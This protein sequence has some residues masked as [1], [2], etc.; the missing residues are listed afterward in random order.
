MMQRFL[1]SWIIGVACLGCRP[2]EMKSMEELATYVND[3]ENGLAIQTKAGDFTFKTTVLPTDRLVAMEI[4]EGEVKPDTVDKW[5]KHFDDFLYFQLSISRNGKEALHQLEDHAM[6]AELVNVLS[7]QM[8]QHVN[9]TTASDTIPVHDYILNRTYGLSES[10]DLLFSFKREK[11][12]NNEWIQFNVNEF[13]LGVGNQRFRF[14]KRD[15][16]AVPTIRFD[17]NN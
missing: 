9:L 16:D 1:M 14:R 8:E 15:I 3:V 7:F 17:L 13:G 6:Y 10:S 11:I 4:G 2:A 5:R 12:E